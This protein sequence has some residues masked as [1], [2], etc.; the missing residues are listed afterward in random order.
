[1]KS[2][3]LN[4]ICM[5]V[6]LSR[7][8]RS[9]AWF[10]V[11]LFYLELLAVPV[12]AR[13]GERYGG[14][15][16]QVHFDN[17][18]LPGAAVHLTGREPAVTAA[19]PV[20]AD[21]PITTIDPE[22]SRRA[23]IQKSNKFTTAGVARRSP[24]IGGP[25]QPEM[26]SF[27]SVNA[28]NMVD[29]F[30]GDFSYNIP[31]LDVGGY[32]VNIHY[33]SGI[34]M[35]QE[36]SWC[37]L[38]WNITPGQISRNMRGLPDDFQGGADHVTKTVHVK[39]NRTVGVSI[40]GGIELF[41]LPMNL[42]VSQSIFHNT[43][44]G[45]GQEGG[46]N[47]SI[48]SGNGSKGSLSG[49]LSITSNSQNGVN[50][51]P[52]IGVTLGSN[53]KKAEGSVSIGANYNS[54]AGLQSLQITGELKRNN[55]AKMD[56]ETKKMG[57]RG[58]GFGGGL[59]SSISFSR[60]SY[61]PTISLPYTSLQ[62]SLSG[63]IG[64]ELWGLD[65]HA[66]L[67]A[68]GSVQ[69]I[70][71]AD[72]I[73]THP[74]YGY[75]YYEK[76]NGRNNAL[77]DFNREKDV[78]YTEQ[79]PHIAI[80][81]YTYDTYSITGEGTGGMFRPYRGDI[82]FVHDHTMRTKSDS[83]GISGDFAFGTLFHA[84]GD[85][86]TIL[87][88]TENKPWL[89][90]N[91]MKDMIPFTEKDT[92]YEN[93]YFKNPG[94][95]T[96]V[97]QQYLNNIGD[98][99]LMRVDLLP[100]G[101]KKVPV[102]TAGRTF[103]LF[104]D[105]KNNGKLTMTPGILRKERDK[106]TQVIS[107]LTASDAAIVGLDKTI[108][109]YNINSF[110]VSSCNTNFQT[111]SRYGSI[112]QPNHLSEI[113]VLSS[114]GRRY[115]YGTPVYN[116][117]Q[118]DVNMSTGAGSQQTGMV[119]YSAGSENSAGNN[120]GKEAYFKK[121][122]MS[123]YAHAFL[124]SGILS[125][126][127]T[128][129]TGDGITED[130]PGDAVKFNYT[131]V[132]RED[133]AY[134]WRAPHEREK[135]FYDD[136]LKTDSRDEKGSYS[137]GSKEVWY[138]NSI[139]S[140]T[141][142]ATFLLETD[143]ARLDAHGVLDENGGRDTTQKLYR[144]K[145]INLYT[146]ADYIKNG[147]AAAKP[148]KTV[149]FGYS[150]QLCKKNPDSKA[151]TGKLTLQKIWFT[152]NKNNKGA[153]NPYVFTYHAN[154]PDFNSKMND[155][156][157]N[158]K[159]PDNNPEKDGNKMTNADYPYATWNKD[160]ADYNAAAWTLSA[161]KLPSGGKIK[162]QYESDD[163]AYVQNRRAMQ[164][165]S[166]AGFGDS[167]NA[168]PVNNLYVKDTM[169][170]D[171]RYVFANVTEAVNTKADINRKYLEGVKKLYFKLQVK[172]PEDIWGK[173]YE[174]V[175]CYA[176]IEDYGVKGNPSDKKIWLKLKPL[177][178]KESPLTT[179]VL[180]FLRLN[181]PSKAYPY[182]E[183]GD[184]ISFRSFVGTLSSVI[185]NVGELFSS[186]GSRA[187]SRN[188]CNDVLLEKSFVRLNNPV[189]RKYGGGLR[190]KKI[191]VYDHFN[192]MTGNVK[193]ESIYGQE[194]IYTDT[195][196]IDGALTNISSG[197][198]TYEPMV[199]NDENPFRIP[200]EYKEQLSVLAPVN[201]MYAE[202]P[203]A[204]TFF[205][206]PS[207]GYS[208]V[209]VQSIWKDR[210]SATGAEETE[211][212]TAR[213]FPTLVE[214]TPLDPQTKRRF[215]P[216]LFNMAK[217]NAMHFIALSQ[218][219]KIELN[220]MHGQMKSHASYAQNNVK[221]RISYTKNYYRLENDLSGKQQLANN[222]QFIDSANGK[223]SNGIMGKEVELMVDV[224]EQTSYTVGGS[225]QGNLDFMQVPPP[226]FSIS[227]IPLPNLE[228]DR[229]RSISVLKI[230]NRYGILDSVLHMEKGSVVTT[231]NKIYD[232]ETGDVLLT[233]TNN[234]FDDPV[235]N[236]SYPAHWA[237]TGMGPAYKNLG[238]TI[239]DVE[240][241]RGFLFKGATRIAAERYFESGD[242][243]WVKGNYIR[244][245]ITNDYCADGYYQF[246]AASDEDKGIII[247]AV[248]ASK[249]KE[250]HK[251]I[252]FIDKDGVPFS[253]DITTLTVIRS[254]R[255][256]MAG[257]GIGSVTTMKNPVKTVNGQ[258]R[259]VFDS[260][261][262]VIAAGA[263]K[264]KDFWKV[265]STNYK[266]DT[267]VIGARLAEQGNAAILYPVDNY[268]IRYFQNANS[269][270]HH[271]ENL[272]TSVSFEAAAKDYGNNG[273]EEER[274]SWL[275]YHL[276]TTVLPRGAVII[277]AQ[278]T[279]K[280]TTLLPHLNDRGTTNSC[281]IERL[282]G[283][284]VRQMVAGGGADMMKQYFEQTGNGQVDEATRVTIPATT[285]G[286]P[287][288]VTLTVTAMVQDMVD[289]FYQSNK[290]VSPAIRIR[291]VDRTGANNGNW[292]RM[293]YNNQFTNNCV[294]GASAA[295]GA[296]ARAAY[297]VPS[298]QPRISIQWYLPCK[299]G[300]KP[301]YSATPVPGYYCYDVPIDSFVCKPNMNDSSINPYRWGILGN[302]RAERAY[303]YY[304]RRKQSDPATATNI[305]TDGEIS[306][307]MPYWS[308][309][310]SVLNGSLDSSRWVW[311][312]EMSLFNRKGLEIQ[313][314]D[315]LNR[316][317][318]GQYGYNQTLPVAVG[319]NTKSREMMFD[320]FEDYGYRTDTCKRC[321][322]IRHV[323]LA[324]G[325]ALVDTVSHT[326]K[327]SLRLNGNQTLTK[328]IP[329]ATLQ[330]DS[331]P[332]SLSLKLDSTPLIKTAVFSNGTGL[333]MWWL[334]LLKKC[335]STFQSL[336]YTS[337]IDM[338]NKPAAICR[339][340]NYQVLWQGYIQPR[341]SGMYTFHGRADDYL[342]VDIYRNNVAK[343]VT[344]NTLANPHAWN[345]YYKGDTIYLSA[346]ELYF[347]SAVFSQVGGNAFANLKW[348]SEG[349]QKQGYETIPM[350]QLYPTNINTATVKANTTHSDTAW[351]VGLKNPSVKKVTIDRFSP[352]QGKKVVVG[353][354]VKQ[355]MLCINGNYDYVQ[356]EL[357]FNNGGQN[358]FLLK[359]KGNIIDGWQRIEDTL[360][361]PAAATSLDFSMK[362]TSSS[363]V[364][365]DDIR[366][367]PFNANMKSFVYNPVNIR[368][369]AELDENNYATFY[370][371][372]DDG[373]L[374]RLKKETE[375]G[376]KTIK[377][378]R[379]ALLK[380]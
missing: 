198:A 253:G 177:K 327:F 344:P 8:P 254:G 73:A 224:R 165:F 281:Y 352:L 318:A 264:M 95:R 59:G 135:A 241:R 93:V 275:R 175:P 54:R 124:L 345:D 147:P 214:W 297:S 240:F 96:A 324:S 77:L 370:E 342:V 81:I 308:F 196:R 234:E 231:R 314:H 20:F 97:H 293:A 274:K 181:M 349:P 380:E 56:P 116:V 118:V 64:G 48:N 4:N 279:L 68:Y 325:G 29:L 307:F 13:A 320:G 313:N 300:V 72:T 305:R 114:D 365:F 357:T 187:R 121:E 249:G 10:F 358:Y 62:L 299:P 199:G 223:I 213:D 145:Q 91:A 90:D 110:P 107:F 356:L 70:A 256:N 182:S 179:T 311:N 101:D 27:Q 277:S 190:V 310:D 11:S 309:T 82:G 333:S 304:S 237:Y 285:N 360:T 9:I 226:I 14:E 294:S 206:S 86:S 217:I 218:G 38:G 186:Y 131:R 227:V 315:P 204:E 210:K 108:R 41:G 7:H 102:I 298:C 317:N 263:V 247:W 265:D 211:F 128:D 61:T 153:R 16:C 142:I 230:V 316:Y 200:I 112:R 205:P 192:T 69:R 221:D 17:L 260:T 111:I 123:P 322:D 347:I 52:S 148:I 362:S 25:T 119:G 178:G 329:I 331:M 42:G 99:Q 203:F 170:H 252:Y 163:Y 243:I 222:V 94:E 130:D 46:L 149:H 276:D 139:E 239:Q 250:G 106:R 367:H 334:D 289:K 78:A 36:S 228:T 157:G 306:G 377:E 168:T 6:F 369:M 65:V 195:V 23:L 286:E 140:K 120:K 246:A 125:P 193:Q 301:A 58:F 172:V 282:R 337:N 245:S 232:S 160:S 132:Y 319:Q 133:S 31:L 296:N 174:T 236:F 2:S 126:E 346:G 238:T 379:S 269:S 255:R 47:V 371:Y 212:Y 154:N 273:S 100:E 143:S 244:K 76:A 197:V 159:H 378:T 74:A 40:G 372:D 164:L 104:K 141:M 354:W 88:W 261:T 19:G 288:D 158:Y 295:G 303:T 183:P 117:Q 152:Y 312:S 32:P 343:R 66:H 156:W 21:K 151:D 376:V 155:R 138:M 103:S 332:A 57:S 215:N 268:T 3:S 15:T 233:E 1:M 49:G 366:V 67:S 328:T 326:G 134:R 122:Q 5:V 184:E 359:P 361:I 201:Y 189:Y 43:Y 171:Y 368:L 115:I 136:G 351:C 291:L 284:Y 191:E 180:Q 341:Y 167:L 225:L 348:E 278:L 321:L 242:E 266:K 109:S 173:G 44:K 271:Y 335:N 323:E 80:P 229:Y 63:K 272:A 302:W 30:T 208:K 374:T 375:R 338:N 55:P 146:K 290:T 162:V 209:R 24:R 185:G 28:N 355:E 330:Q 129:I 18:L 166:L 287:K 219:F 353:A 364:Y 202:E 79:T 188:H 257:A 50:V 98:D 144:L 89:G 251:G 34:T 270:K 220:D 83:Y 113:T 33:R 150:Y 53:E 51:N 216:T 161:V 363:P 137:Y 248:E 35:D 336:G 259:L 373:T 105:G 39:D 71:S 339:F 283:P 87:A 127:Y 85:L 280:G 258:L 84:G 22:H 176:E 37:G 194:Y 75:L 350:S 340:G 235:Y 267:T 262:G 12:T 60:P 169:I 26:Q 45:W 207:V 92:T 292:S